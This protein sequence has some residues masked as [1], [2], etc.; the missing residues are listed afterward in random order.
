MYKLFDR[1]APWVTLFAAA[2][3]LALAIR[4]VI[5]WPSVG[6]CYGIIV[7]LATLRT[8]QHRREAKRNKQ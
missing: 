8:K 1:Y 5:S 7:A 3:I 2:F 6:L 4:G